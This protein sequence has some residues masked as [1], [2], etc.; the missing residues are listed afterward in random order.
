VVQYLSIA[1]T[2]NSS[3]FIVILLNDTSVAVRVNREASMW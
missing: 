1:S 3:G 2:D